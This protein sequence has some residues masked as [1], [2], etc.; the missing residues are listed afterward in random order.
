MINLFETKKV[1]LQISS[2]ENIQDVNFYY[3][4]NMSTMY[5]KYEMEEINPSSLYEYELYFENEQ[6]LQVNYYFEI[7]TTEN[8]YTYPMNNPKINPIRANIISISEKDNNFVLLTPDSHSEVQGSEITIAISYFH[9]QDIIDKE[10][11]RFLI[12]RKDYTEKG[13]VTNNL[14]LIN[15]LKLPADNYSYSIKA[16]TKNNKTPG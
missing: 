13:T 11:I 15:N 10:S 9:I 7:I 5:T 3:K 12:N 4:T 8:T 14:F 1:R 2:T 16:K 6:I